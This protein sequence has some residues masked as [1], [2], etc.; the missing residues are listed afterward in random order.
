[1]R[2]RHDAAVLGAIG[3]PKAEPRRDT[4]PHDQLTAMSGTMVRAAQSYQIVCFVG[5]AILARFNV[6]HIN[7][8]DVATT[9]RLAAV[10]VSAQHR[11]SQSG[12]HVLLRAWSGDARRRR[13]CRVVADVRAHVGVAETLPIAACHFDDIS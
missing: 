10:L 11:T 1:M 3:V 4:P 6:V 5:S 9:W 7:E 13:R 2:R 8:S 12:W